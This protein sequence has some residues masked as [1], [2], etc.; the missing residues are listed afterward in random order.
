MGQTKDKMLGLFFKA[1]DLGNHS[2]LAL[3][4]QLLPHGAPNRNSKQTQPGQALC[5]TACVAAV[6]WRNIHFKVTQLVK[7]T[8]DFSAQWQISP[9]KSH[10]KHQ[11]TKQNKTKKSWNT[12]HSSSTIRWRRIYEMFWALWMVNIVYIFFCLHL[13]IIYCYRYR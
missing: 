1:C 5:H 4:P 7:A 6:R 12:S 2:S 9:E 8:Q 11:K 10:F 13:Q 3:D